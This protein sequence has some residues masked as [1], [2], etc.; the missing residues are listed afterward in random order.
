MSVDVLLEFDQ[1]KNVVENP[2]MYGIPGDMAVLYETLNIPET[3]LTTPTTHVDFW[4]KSIAAFDKT[5][6]QLKAM[7]AMVYALYTMA[8]YCH[9]ILTMFRNA[10]SI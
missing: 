4:P 1:F 10:W 7:S 6:L 3:S 8:K 2:Q 9:V 5:A